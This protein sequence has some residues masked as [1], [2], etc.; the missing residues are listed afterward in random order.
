VP[1]EA[2]EEEP[3]PN[4]TLG[5]PSAVCHLRWILVFSPVKAEE[6]V[7]AKPFLEGHA[8]PLKVSMIAEGMP[9]EVAIL[10]VT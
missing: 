3:S 9:V 1:S 4:H 7:N 5:S 2:V 6:M 10:E 8:K